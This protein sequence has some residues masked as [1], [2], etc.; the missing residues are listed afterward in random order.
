M[1]YIH[2]QV[3]EKKESAEVEEPVP[4]TA[5]LPAKDIRARRRVPEAHGPVSRVGRCLLYVVFLKE[6][7]G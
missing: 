1:N 5:K 4:V 2:R 7:L 6:A 3:H